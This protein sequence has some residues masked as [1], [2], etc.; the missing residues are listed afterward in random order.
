MNRTLISI[1]SLYFRSLLIPFIVIFS[2]G[3]E[4]QFFTSIHFTQNLL[5]SSSF[6]TNFLRFLFNF[7]NF[8][9]R[10][11]CFWF[12][13]LL[14]FIWVFVSFIHFIQRWWRRPYQSVTFTHIT[15]WASLICIL[16]TNQSTNWWRWWYTSGEYMN[17]QC[18][19]WMQVDA[20]SQWAMKAHTLSL[21][22]Y[23]IS[24]YEWTEWTEQRS[25]ELC[26]HIRWS[27]INVCEEIK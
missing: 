26:H 9:S 2:F 25:N 18:D 5:I 17:G 19:S 15:I 14:N 3:F 1:C 7:S 27:A 23:R 10:C 20:R 16:S 6:V 4:F 22:T 8:R 13:C 21:E 24:I 11:W 12:E